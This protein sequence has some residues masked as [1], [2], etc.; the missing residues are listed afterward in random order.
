MS[1]TARQLSALTAHAL[2]YQPGAKGSASAPEREYFLRLLVAQLRTQNPLRPYEGQEFAVQLAIF[3]QVEQLVAMRQLLE[4]QLGQ[5]SGLMETMGNASAPA[6]VGTFARA[7]SSMVWLP[8]D[9]GVQFGYELPEAAEEVRVEILTPAG[10]TVRVLEFHQVRAGVHTVEWDGRTASGERLP[11]GRYAVRIIAKD[12]AQQSREV[13]PFVEGIV[14]AV[15]FTEGG[16]FVIIN[17]VEVP[18]VAVREI[19]KRP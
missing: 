7:E 14:E 4:V 6:L 3:S 11:A 10:E 16:A 5:F 13:I 19:R 18:L 17:G 1:A 15:R 12:G 9:G 8:A 2:G